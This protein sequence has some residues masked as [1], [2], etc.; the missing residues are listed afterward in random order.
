MDQSALYSVSAQKG[1]STVEYVLLL[2]VIMT[3]TITILSSKPFQ[4]FLGPESEFLTVL[5]NR[6]EYSYRHGIPGAED[7]SNYSALNHESYIAEGGKTHFFI[8]T[9]ADGYS[10]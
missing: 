4:D 9:T 6:M 8:P 1:Q 5:K 10:E 7:E 2:G 3:L